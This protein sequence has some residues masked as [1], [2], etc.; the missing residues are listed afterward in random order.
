MEMKKNKGRHGVK[1]RPP[2]LFSPKEKPE[3]EERD[4]EKETKGIVECV[5]KTPFKRRYIYCIN[6]KNN[7]LRRREAN[8]FAY[9]VGLEINPFRWFF[10]N[11]LF[12]LSRRWVRWISDFKQLGGKTSNYGLCK[13]AHWTKLNQMKIARKWWEK[14]DRKKILCKQSSSLQLAHRLLYLSSFTLRL[15]V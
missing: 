13:H 6:T 10:S 8:W 12:L 5:N 7:F 15:T 3:L 1:I 11:F 2:N 14:T 9:E 4:R